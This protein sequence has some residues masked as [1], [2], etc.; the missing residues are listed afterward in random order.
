[1]IAINSVTVLGAGTMAGMGLSRQAHA[2][3][4]SASQAL[5]ELPPFGNVSFLHMT[6]CHAQL[7]PIH[8]REPSV[9][10]GFGSM[11]GQLPH[12]VGEHLLRACGVQAGTATAHALTHL[13]FEQ[14]AQRYGRVGGFA[15]LAT[16]VKRM[17]ASRPGALLLDGGDEGHAR[18]DEA[19]L[20]ELR[21][22]LAEVSL[23]LRF[24]HLKLVY[25][26]LRAFQI[27]DGLAGLGVRHLAQQHERHLRLLHHHAGEDRGH[28]I[29]LLNGRWG[30]SHG[31]GSSVLN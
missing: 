19:L 14:A 16:L 18:A 24:E 9:N 27:R 31:V 10:L 11:K 22:V 15:H 5:Y 13:D 4:N 1:M 2:D 3:I 25:E 23:G 12:L 30:Q 20:E 8:F 17:K 28:R 7:K 29:V 26:H 21:L 6:D